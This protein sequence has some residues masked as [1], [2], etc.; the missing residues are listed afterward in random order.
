MFDILFD[1]FSNT[2]ELVGAVFATSS[3]D[4]VAAE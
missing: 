3:F 4:G 1:L 2:L